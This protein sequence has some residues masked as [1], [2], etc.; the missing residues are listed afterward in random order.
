MFSDSDLRNIADPPG[1]FFQ[2]GGIHDGKVLA[3]SFDVNRQIME[4]MLDDIYSNFLDF[5]EYPGTTPAQMIFSGLN[6]FS[7]DVDLNELPLAIA[8]IECQEREGGGLYSLSISLGRSGSMEISC[9]Q[10]SITS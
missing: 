10:I 1:L 9:Q 5:P 3:I 6:K 7:C 2:L 4:V 8:I